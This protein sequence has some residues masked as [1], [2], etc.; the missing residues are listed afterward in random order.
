MEGGEDSIPPAS[1]ASGINP[2]TYRLTSEQFQIAAVK[3]VALMSGA[4]SIAE[5]DALTDQVLSKTE[6]TQ[7]SLVK[8]T[9]PLVPEPTI[10]RPEQNRQEKTVKIG[11]YPQGSTPKPSRSG[12]QSQ[13]KSLTDNPFY[14]PSGSSTEDKSDGEEVRFEKEVQGQRKFSNSSKSTLNDTER[15]RGTPNTA[16]S[17]APKQV[18]ADVEVELVEVESGKHASHPEKDPTDRTVEGDKQPKPAREPN[19]GKERREYSAP[20]PSELMACDAPGPSKEKTL[21]RNESAQGGQRSDRKKIQATRKKG[22]GKGKGVGKGTVSA[23]NAEE[24]TPQPALFPQNGICPPTYPGVWY[25]NKYHCG[26][27]NW[28]S[29]H[30]CSKCGKPRDSY[31]GGRGGGGH[32]GF[33]RGGSR[34]TGGNRGR[35]RTYSTNTDRSSNRDDRQYSNPGNERGGRGGPSWRY[36]GRNGR[37]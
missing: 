27:R 6:T 36:R 2:Q 21:H 13:G 8:E 20:I 3:F 33:Q 23:T 31:A 37:W 35:G 15:G 18:V 10:S 9:V 25:C 32:R 17:L 28:P 16:R 34:G 19:M 1:S 12:S 29:S 4:S 7:D 24:T 11:N 26:G 5:R 22:E 30:C 14:N